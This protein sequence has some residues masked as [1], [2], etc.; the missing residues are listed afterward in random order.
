MSTNPNRHKQTKKAKLKAQEA[1]K[2]TETY[3]F[4]CIHMVHINL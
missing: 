2:D 1:N 4:A 3:A